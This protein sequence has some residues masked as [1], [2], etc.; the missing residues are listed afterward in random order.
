MIQDSIFQNITNPSSEGGAI[1]SSSTLKLV[2]SFEISNST[3]EYCSSLRGG[4]LSIE[5]MQLT[6]TN[7]TSFYYNY[8]L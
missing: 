8:A 2:N 7:Q 6:I 1:Y 4:A 5:D 3:F